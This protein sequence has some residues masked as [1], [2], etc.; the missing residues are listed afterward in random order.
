MASNLKEYIVTDL[1]ETVASD[2]TDL[3]ENNDVPNNDKTTEDSSVASVVDIDTIS[4]KT[5]GVAR[6]VIK[7]RRGQRYQTK[8]LIR[9]KSPQPSGQVMKSVQENVTE[10]QDK[11]SSDS[12]KEGSDNNNQQPESTKTMSNSSDSQ[13]LNP[14][15]VV[16]DGKRLV[17]CNICHRRMTESRLANHIRLM[18]IVRMDENSSSLQRPK[19]YRCEHCGKAYAIKYTYD[20][21]IRTHTEGRPKC[22]ECGSTFASAFSLFRHRAKAH[23]LEHS[24]TTHKCNLCDKI[25][26]SLSELNLHIQ[27]HSDQKV[28]T[29]PECE[30]SFSAKGN[31]RIHMRTHAKEKLYQCDICANTFSHP[32]SLVSHRRIHT[33]EFPYTCT[34]CGKSK[35]DHRLFPVQ[36][37]SIFANHPSN[38]L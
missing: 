16:T 29:C 35:F 2:S 8:D 5:A 12:L 1:L 13:P 25:F 32:Y 18:H 31:L 3:Q 38:Q 24:Y 27:R 10:S 28:H 4:V 17:E 9:E 30:K 6:R 19:D 26:F 37:Y 11:G 7:Q 33:N 34:E 23:N 15:V 21:H 22:P 20:Q 36:F 14:S